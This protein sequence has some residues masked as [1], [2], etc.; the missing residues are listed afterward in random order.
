MRDDLVATMNADRLMILLTFVI[1]LA[2]IGEVYLTWQRR[3]NRPAEHPFMSQDEIE[4]LS[5]KYALA[6]KKH[7]PSADIGDRLRKART[8]ALKRELGV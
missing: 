5:L 8:E 4:E 7:A 6:R 2:C 3:R 1:L